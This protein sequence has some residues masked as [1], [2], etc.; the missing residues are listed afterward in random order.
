M[1]I[2]QI[3]LALPL[4]ALGWLGTLASISVLSDAAPAQVAL[5]PRPGFL[6][7]LQ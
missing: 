5:L 2:R 3:L 7:A 4:L 6:A 1:T